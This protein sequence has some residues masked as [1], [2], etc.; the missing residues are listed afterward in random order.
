MPYFP[1][2][3]GAALHYR[4]LGAEG[5]G[6]GRPPLLCLAGGPARDAAYLGDLGGLSAHRPLIVP[7]ARGTGHSERAD[8]SPAAAD[9]A[10]YAFPRLADDLEAL[11]DHLGLDRFALLA[12]DAA[13]ATA[14]AYAAAHPD[15]LS[16]LVLLNPGSRL[17]GQLPEDARQI[18]AARAAETPEDAERWQDVHTAVRQLK[19]ATDLA[20]VRQLL[21]RAAPMAYAHWRAPQRAHAATEGDQL[22]PVPRAGFWQ[23]VDEPTRTE[24][25]NGLTKVDAP[26]LIVT[27]TLDAVTGVRA[28]D[29]VAA[30][31]PHSPRVHHHALPG[32]GHYPWVDAPG[33]LV[34][35][36]V[37]FLRE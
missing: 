6:R 4:V 20:E 22:N 36:V 15:R 3:D 28:G 37:D 29:A 13:A 12:H 25:L 19:N 11:R 32:A 5:H 30:S 33:S 7:D 31:F 21:L 23:G 18:L 34:R 8:A 26:V 14:Q 2:Y 16:H 10:G 35:L 9:P 24:I 27:G 1:S 17:Q